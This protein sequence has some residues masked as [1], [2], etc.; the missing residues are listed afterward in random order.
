MANAKYGVIDKYGKILI[1]PSYKGLYEFAY[2]GNSEAV[3][4]TGK[5]LKYSY[6]FTTDTLLTD[7]SYLGISKQDGVSILRCGIVDAY[8]K[9]ILKQG[10]YDYVM[11]PHSNMVRY[12]IAKKKETICGYHN[13]NTGKSFQ[14]TKIDTPLTEIKYWT[15][16]D[17][18]GDIAPV[19]GVSWSFVDKTG[20]TVRGGYKKIVW[21]ANMNLWGAQNNKGTW[22]VFDSQNKDIAALSGY[23]AITFPT[24]EGDQEVL[25]VRKGSQYGG[26]NR[27]GNVVI[28][29]EYDDMGANVFDVVAVKRNGKWGIVSVNNQLLIPLEYS[30]VRMPVERN[31]QHFWVMKSDSLWYHFHITGQTIYKTGYRA[32]SNFVNGIAMVVPVN[33]TLEDTSINRA[34]LFQPNALAAD[35]ET[36]DLEKAKDSFG[37][38]LRADDNEIIFNRPVSIL[39]VNSVATAV[40]E[41][42]NRILTDLEKK[43]LL[44]EVTKDNRSYALTGDYNEKF[45]SYINSKASKRSK[46]DMK[47]KTWQFFQDYAL[48][49]EK[50]RLSEN[51]WNY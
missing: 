5:R 14:A 26:I 3:Y 47:L 13:L 16:G 38:I 18:E 30:S 35:L 15:H 4:H 11:M 46:E 24:H 43:N 1:T 17:F 51:E 39:Y 21:G 12:Y 27:N 33:L 2:E 34:Q 19:N 6:H 28:P 50:D 10:L 37:Y 23:E 20:R 48:E 9:E 31:A 29:F 22:D 45:L 49:L 36:A 8:G 7:C 32:T 25:S 41:K 44:L 42:G 40:M